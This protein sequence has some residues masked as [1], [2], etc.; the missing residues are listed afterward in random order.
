MILRF[1]IREADMSHSLLNG[2]PPDCIPLIVVAADDFAAWLERQ[3]DFLRGWLRATGF[4]AKPGRFKLIPSP[5]GTLKAVVVCI[6]RADDLWLS[7][8]HI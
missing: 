2:R 6:K 7:L 3:D 5:D 1:A 8:I 4:K